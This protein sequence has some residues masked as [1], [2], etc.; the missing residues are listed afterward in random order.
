M[1]STLPTL[2]GVGSSRTLGRWFAVGIVRQCRIVLRRKG[3]SAVRGFDKG[4]LGLLARTLRVCFAHEFETRVIELKTV[5][6]MERLELW[7]SCTT[8]P[9]VLKR[10]LQLLDDVLKDMD[11]DFFVLWE[12]HFALWPIAS[13]S[14]ANCSAY[15]WKHESRISSSPYFQSPQPSASM[16]RLSCP[17]FTLLIMPPMKLW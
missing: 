17:L 11:V 14:S 13:T 1:P 2:F 5:V 7:K 12:S 9:H 15:S 10:P 3:A 8:L 4:F 6:A 16:S